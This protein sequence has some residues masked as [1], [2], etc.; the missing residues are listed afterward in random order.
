[1]RQE[2]NSPNPQ[3]DWI[4]NALMK[5]ALSRM[6]RDARGGPSALAAAI[7]LAASIGATYGPALDVPFIFDD[8][9]SIVDNRSITALWPLYGTEEHPGPLNPPFDTPCGGRPL[10]NL[11]YAMNYAAGGLD[12]RGYHATNVAIHFLAAMV[13]WSIVRQTL[14]L[15]RFGERFLQASAW[16]ALMT[17]L[18]WALHPLQTEAVIYAT[19]RTELLMALFYL[20]TLDCSL[21]YWQSSEHVT[22]PH[23]KSSRAIWLILATASCACGMASKEVM[24]SAPVVVLLFERTFL[25]GSFLGA[26][27]R[28]WPLYIGLSATWVVLLWLNLDAP[29]GTA[30]GFGVDLPVTVWWMT[31]CQVLL[32]YM[33]LVVWPSPLL[34]HYEWP[35]L[36]TLG[37][38]WIYVALVAMLGVAILVL[39]W[40]NTPIGF[41]GTA[42]AAILAP[43]SL[44][45][46]LTETAAERRMYLPLA[47]LIVLFVVGGYHLGRSLPRPREVASP[48]INRGAR[49]GKT[50]MVL[51]LLLAIGLG[52]I[53]ARRLSA[54]ADEMGLWRQVLRYQPNSVMALTGLGV[55]LVQAGEFNDAA[56][57]LKSAVVVDPGR[58]DAV[59]YLAKSLAA[60]N[61]KP[62]AIEVLKAAVPH[63]RD[64]PMELNNIGLALV[65]LGAHDDGMALFR[66]AIQLKPKLRAARIYLGNALLEV[67]NEEEGFDVLREAI[68]L[69]PESMEAR[70]KLGDAM[71]LAGRADEAVT[72]FESALAIDPN[73]VVCLNN[74]SV[75][76]MQLGRFEDARDRLQQAL[77]VDPNYAVTHTNMGIWLNHQGQPGAAVSEFETAIRLNPQEV[78]ALRQLAEWYAAASETEKA[79]EFYRAVLR[80]SP[81]WLDVRQNLGELLLK[82]GRTPEAIELLQATLQLEPKHMQSYMDLARALALADRPEEAIDYAEKGIDIARAA[83]SEHA[84]GVLE[85]W[86]H[87]YRLEIR[88]HQEQVIN[89]E[90]LEPIERP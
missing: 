88:R 66:Q 19:Q 21:R 71:I 24:V 50:A 70:A 62:E 69:E 90:R 57:V 89:D 86:L 3:S 43:T 64:E 6:L 35:Y 80:V 5:H 67:G 11:T 36:T 54:Y 32:M 18:I 63:S 4:P 75:A 42:F 49:N 29:R 48:A 46:I 52:A 74:L 77:N 59:V 68:R 76:L 28:S 23:R 47:A 20:V 9:S 25:S 81:M 40:R 87:H 41:L 39:L 27:R 84:A 82:I 85:Q 61:R 33:K 30:A 38:S 51:G 58:N 65:K 34:I 31:Q 26:M 22:V 55:L 2:L 60:S 53:S 13:L 79:I 8:G 83:G 16:L 15:P 17:A 45:P 37:D 44:V 14:R 12:P 1:M 7:V 78:N 72:V 56:D 10:V 73:D